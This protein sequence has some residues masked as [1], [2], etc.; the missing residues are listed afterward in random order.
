MNDQNP[1]SV[2]MFLSLVS[3]A[4]MGRSSSRRKRDDNDDHTEGIP[5]TEDPVEYYDSDESED[6]DQ[7]DEDDNTEYYD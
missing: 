2:D 5:M 6:D 7:V 3:D 4:V 1:E